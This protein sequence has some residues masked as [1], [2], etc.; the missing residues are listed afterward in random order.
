MDEPLTLISIVVISLLILLLVDSDDDNTGGGLPEPVMIPL[1]ISKNIR[2][3][4]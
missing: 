4:R 1:P 2:G 3:N